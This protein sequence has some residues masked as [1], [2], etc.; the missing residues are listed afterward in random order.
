MFPSWWVWGAAT[1][2][3]SPCLLLRISIFEKRKTGEMHVSW[4][5]P[6]PVVWRTTAEQCSDQMPLSQLVWIVNTPSS[7]TYRGCHQFPMTYIKRS[8]VTTKVWF[9]PQTLQRKV[10]WRVQAITVVPCHPMLDE[11]HLTEG[12]R[13][14]LV[15]DSEDMAFFCLCSKKDV[16]S[17]QG[18]EK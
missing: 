2:H 8:A 3:A 7:I 6:L 13:A 5:P 11:L 10:M 14:H 17:Q 4:E 18:D 12:I 16:H 15:S 1:R 9:S